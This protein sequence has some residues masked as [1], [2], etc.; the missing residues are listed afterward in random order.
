MRTDIDALCE[1]EVQVPRLR[2]LERGLNNA[3]VGN[4]D[5]SLSLDLHPTLTTLSFGGTFGW[6]KL[7]LQIAAGEMRKTSEILQKSKIPQ[8]AFEFSDP[9]S[10]FV[11]VIQVG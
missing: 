8:P 9:R 2:K 3:A 7:E 4:T 1:G 5:H 11:R 10:N 6:L